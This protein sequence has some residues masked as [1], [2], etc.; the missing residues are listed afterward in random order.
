MAWWQTLESGVAALADRFGRNSVVEI[1]EWVNT[2][3]ATNAG[4]GQ[5]V[6]RG[7]KES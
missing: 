4:R 7:K 3:A 5:P 6:R 2:P 1:A